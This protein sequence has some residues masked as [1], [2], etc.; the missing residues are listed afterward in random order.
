MRLEAALPLMLDGL[1]VDQRATV[2]Q[3][4]ET[5]LG[6][7]AGVY[8]L[9]DYVNFKGEGI[10]IT[11]RYNGRGWGLLQVLLAMRGDPKGPDATRAFSEAADRV[12]TERVANSP[13]ERG[14]A[15]WL[16]GWRSRVRTYAS[17]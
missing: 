6:A 1:P 12:L 14:E 13:R 4:F 2:R 7:R 5:V 8:A 16:P 15:R 9:V 17:G 3:R 10:K 11:E